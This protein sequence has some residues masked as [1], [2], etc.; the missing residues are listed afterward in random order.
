MMGTK[1]AS[2]ASYL[3]IPDL[4]ILLRSFSRRHPDLSLIQHFKVLTQQRRILLMGW[5]KQALYERCQQSTQMHRLA[6]HLRYFPDVPVGDVDYER[7]AERRLQL[8]E[9]G[10]TASSRQL[11]LWVVA[12]RIGAHV[13]SRDRNWQSLVQRGCQLYQEP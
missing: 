4:D 7:L 10:I 2:V 1:D 9:K 13:W 6:Q 3:V 12:E 11:Y 8:R 5:V